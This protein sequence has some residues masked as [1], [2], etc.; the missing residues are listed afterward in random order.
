MFR[1]LAVV[2]F[3]AV[4]FGEDKDSD[5]KAAFAALPMCGKSDFVSMAS[6]MPQG[7]DSTF[8]DCLKQ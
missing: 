5:K 8:N 3:I 7:G 6:R 2:C 1:Q 4:V